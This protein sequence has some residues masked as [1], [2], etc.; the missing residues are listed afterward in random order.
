MIPTFNCVAA[1]TNKNIINDNLHNVKSNLLYTLDL[2]KIILYDS[3][4]TLNTV[5]VQGE[6]IMFGAGTFRL[7]G[8]SLLT[9]AEENGI[10]NRHQLAMAS[11]ISYQSIL[12]LFDDEPLKQLNILVLAKLLINGVGYTPAE[13]ESVKLSDIFEYVSENELGTA[14]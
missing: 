6:N 2:L 10:E 4:M 8:S 3:F 9:K 11:G 14:A 7:K 1:A 5:F 12:K 13:L